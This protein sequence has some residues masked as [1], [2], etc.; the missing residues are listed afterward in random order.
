VLKDNEQPYFIVDTAVQDSYVLI[1]DN[2]GHL[3]KKNDLAELQKCDIYVP[4][5]NVVNLVNLR[6]AHYSY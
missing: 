1:F 4:N 6:K 2:E 3:F 5:E